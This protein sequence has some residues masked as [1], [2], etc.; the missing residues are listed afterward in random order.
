MKAV[1]AGAAVL[2]VSAGSGF[3]QQAASRLTFEV[4]SIRASPPDVSGA[5][6]R[7]LGGGGFRMTGATLKNVI[8]YAYGVREFLVS[9]GPGW[10]E[11]ERFDIEG[12][13]GS[14]PSEADPAKDEQRERIERV[15]DLLAD[16]FR[17]V[18]HRETREQP[19]YALVTAKGGPKFHESG[20]SNSRIR[21]YRGTIS[22]HAAAIGLLA[23]NLS[24][25][26]ER[27]VIDKTGLSGKYD[28]E[29]KWAPEAVPPADADPPSLFTALSEQL[30]LRLES[31]KAPV[32]VFVIDAVEKPTE[33]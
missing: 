14:S 2:F 25:A 15:R 10:V 26:L 11:T 20:E 30:G 19:V 32:E 13:V 12:R 24:N 28:F 21:M 5:V 33:N 16:R 18:S 1:W 29:L 9:G 6:V 27:R 22:G 17:L 31:Q 8:A 4:A 7:P 23:L 3:G